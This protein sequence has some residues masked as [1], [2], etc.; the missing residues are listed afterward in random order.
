MALL[1][2]GASAWLIFGS[3]VIDCDRLAP[4]TILAV[5]AAFIIA[6]CFRLLARANSR[7]HT[8]LLVF[9]LLLAAAS[10][11]ENVRFVRVHRAVCRQL[12]QQM[13]Q[14]KNQPGI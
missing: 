6:L 1:V 12:Q 2:T 10:L 4:L 13:D 9:A 5:L 14:F 11:F 3:N 7:A 8:W